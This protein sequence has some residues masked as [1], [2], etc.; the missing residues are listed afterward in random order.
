MLKRFVMIGLLGISVSGMLWTAEAHYV[1]TF[2]GWA[3]HSVLCSV[4]L[5]SVPSPDA[6][7][8]VVTCEVITLQIESLCAVPGNDNLVSGSSGLQVVLVGETPLSQGNITDKKKGKAHVDVVVGSPDG[9]PNDPPLDNDFCVN[10]NWTNIANLIRSF[11]SQIKTFKCL[12]DECTSTLLVSTVEAQC[13]LPPEFNFDGYDHNG[14]PPIPADDSCPNCP[15]VGEAYDCPDP[16][17]A[18]VN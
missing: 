3:W 16:V 6:H 15:E 13:T 18:H 2:S 14:T 9:L 7:P 10:P 12:S 11:K 5:K 4:D 17:I 8:A 1:P